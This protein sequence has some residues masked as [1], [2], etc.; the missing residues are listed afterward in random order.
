MVLIWQMM[1]LPINVD[2]INLETVQSSLTLLMDAYYD[3]TMKI[4]AYHRHNLLLL[5]DNLSL[6]D[7]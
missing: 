5:A 3:H 1:L 2:A 4:E 6:C 7:L